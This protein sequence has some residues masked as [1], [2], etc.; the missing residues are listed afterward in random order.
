MNEEIEAQL[1]GC[2]IVHNEE[3]SVGVDWNKVICAARQ[4]PRDKKW[5][6]VVHDVANSDLDTAPTQDDIANDR[7]HAIEMLCHL[8]KQMVNQREI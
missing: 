6:V 3:D 4:R 1:P 2:R 8:A 5:I 7:S